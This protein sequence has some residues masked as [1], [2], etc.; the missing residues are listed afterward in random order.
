MFLKSRE[1]HL[2]LVSDQQ[3]VNIIPVLFEATRPKV[4][5]LL[6]SQAMK[7]KSLLLK[8]FLKELRCTVYT[9]PIDSYDIKSIRDQ[10]L[11]SLKQFEGRTI[12]LNITG[13]TKIMALGA[14]EAM[15]SS[16]SHNQIIYLDSVNQQLIQLAPNFATCQLPNILDVP[17]AL[18]SYGFKIR[19][20]K[21]KVSAKSTKLTEHLVDQVS[22][23]SKSLAKLNYYTYKAGQVD[24]LRVKLPRKEVNDKYLL[25]IINLFKTYGMLEFDNIDCLSFPNEDK[26]IYVNGGWLEE[27]VSN[28]V[29]DLVFH[30][31]IYDYRIDLE[32][33]SSSG[34][35]NEID[36]AFTANNR[37][38]LIECKTVN[39]RSFR[40]FAKGD[41]AAYKLD[42][43]RD[44]MAGT[45]GKA[46]IISYQK[47]TKHDRQRCQ[48]LGIDLIEAKEIIDLNSKLINWISS[49]N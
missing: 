12:T 49:K 38:H 43:L 2:C 37:L 8:S 25:E 32:V 39:Y 44:I 14:F 3:I 22:Y 11:K 35:K 45:F 7:E 48:D 5:V 26:R 23:Y 16:N 42:S 20:T 1:I 15:I 47:V 13:G 33:I 34:T 9:R 18:K 40:N 28:K 17:S 41:Q 6:V 4:V 31:H 46:T 19:K 24:N 21:E 10:I 29:K 27:H 30:G 36:I